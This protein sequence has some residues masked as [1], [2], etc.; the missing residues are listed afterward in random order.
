[1]DLASLFSGAI[2]GAFITAI[3]TAFITGY[4]NIRTKDKEYKYSY[5]KMI[6][7]KRLHAYEELNSLI[8]TLYSS[9]LDDDSKAY[10]LIFS[11]EESFNAFFKKVYFSNSIK[12]WLSDDTNNYLKKISQE[13]TRYLGLISN[14]KNIV[15]IGK[16][17]YKFIAELRDKLE[18]SLLNDMKELYKIDKFFNEKEI[19]T[20]FKETNLSKRPEL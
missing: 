20:I 3:V 11:S 6:L 12:F 2:I 8:H 4:F 9:A 13:L 5:S 14:G 17:E 1:M 7:E 18:Q 19:K 15:T 10:H 16:E